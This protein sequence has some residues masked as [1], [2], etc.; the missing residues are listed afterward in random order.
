MTN[1]N[2]DI[3]FSARDVFLE[4]PSKSKNGKA[5]NIKGFGNNKPKG[6]KHNSKSPL[7]SPITKG[8]QH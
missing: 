1:K 4:S 2:V 6:P 7:W 5:N 3:K 8:G